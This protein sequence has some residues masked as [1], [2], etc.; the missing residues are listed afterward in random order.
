MKEYIKN[1]SSSGE[2][3]INISK[4]NLNSK[5]KKKKENIIVLYSKKNSVCIAN[6]LKKKTSFE[7]KEALL[8]IFIYLFLQ[9]INE[10]SVI[11]E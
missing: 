2:A 5:K 10:L 1:S 8:K 6:S 4:N 9:H 11:T 7:N 3:K